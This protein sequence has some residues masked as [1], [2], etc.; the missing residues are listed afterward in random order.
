MRQHGSLGLLPNQADAKLSANLT[1][2]E[3]F[4]VLFQY[5]DGCA[6]QQVEAAASA[7][8]LVDETLKLS[9]KP[10]GAAGRSI[11]DTA[12]FGL[13]LGVVSHLTEKAL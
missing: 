13:G 9:I 11:D 1:R 4:A 2:P 3:S 6:A 8:I 7:Y 10:A 5:R 12:A